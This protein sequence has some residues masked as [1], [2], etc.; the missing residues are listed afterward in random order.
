MQWTLLWN[1]C[2]TG[3]QGCWRRSTTWSSC[4]QPRDI[5][6]GKLYFLTKPFFYY[7]NVRT[8]LLCDVMTNFLFFQYASKNFIII[9]SLQQT[10]SMRQALWNGWSLAYILHGF[11]FYWWMHK[12]LFHNMPISVR[13]CT[14]HETSLLLWIS[15]RTSTC[16][17]WRRKELMMT[18]K[19]HIWF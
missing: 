7:E 11:L 3:T 1:F 16:L 4:M 17:L 8:N 10:K 12:W 6:S 13:R 19:K 14:R 2:F 15:T 5:L 9:C 18:S